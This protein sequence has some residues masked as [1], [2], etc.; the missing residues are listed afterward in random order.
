ML[1]GRSFPA[2]S[3]WVP[4]A[5]YSIFPRLILAFHQD[6]PDI[7]LVACCN[8][9]IRRECHLMSGQISSRS[10]IC[11]HTKCIKRCFMHVGG[12]SGS[13]TNVSN[14][15]SCMSEDGPDFATSSNVHHRCASGKFNPMLL[16]NPARRIMFSRALLNFFFLD[17]SRNAS[18]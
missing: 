6:A 1:N 7:A 14:G 11:L 3:Y 17:H 8:N 4:V 9:S 2:V 12:W 13:T 16:L 10:C 5:T 15:A 18:H